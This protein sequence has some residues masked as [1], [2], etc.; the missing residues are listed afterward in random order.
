MNRATFNNLAVMFC[1][2]A[3][4]GFGVHSCG[5]NNFA[6]PS[7]AVTAETESSS[8][9]CLCEIEE[10]T[11]HKFAQQASNSSF[12]EKK[13]TAALPVST[14]EVVTTQVFADS[15]IVVHTSD[16]RP[17]DGQWP[18]TLARAHL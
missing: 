2:V 10:Q 1:A 16:P 14:T 6:H 4:L 7:P 18:V 8:Q 3:A 17:P 12:G 13:Q 5:I 11:D 15:F 9:D